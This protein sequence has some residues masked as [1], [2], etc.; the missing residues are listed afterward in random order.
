MQIILVFALVFALL[1]AIFALS[2]AN[3]VIIRL[4]WGSYPMSQALVILGS[5]AFGAIVVL[6]LGLFSQI[7]ARIRIWEYKGKVKKLE[8]ELIDLKELNQKYK[9]ELKTSLEISNAQEKDPSAF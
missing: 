1:V 9:D 8:K 6:M 2:N 5:A 3:E 4:P 7:K